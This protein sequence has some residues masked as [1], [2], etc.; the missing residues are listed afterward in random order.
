LSNILVLFVGHF[1]QGWMSAAVIGIIE[2]V[3][4]SSCSWSACRY[5]LLAVCT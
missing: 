2:G 4:A 3:Q 1:A 5:W